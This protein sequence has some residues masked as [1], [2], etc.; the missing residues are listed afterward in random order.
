MKIYYNENY[1]DHFMLLIDEL[2]D[3]LKIDFNQSDLIFKCYSTYFFQVRSNVNNYELLEENQTEEIVHKMFNGKDID[4]D[5]RN[6]KIGSSLIPKTSILY[7]YSL[8]YHERITKRIEKPCIIKYKFPLFKHPNINLNKY[9][10]VP[11]TNVLF[12]TEVIGSPKVIEHNKVEYYLMNGSYISL[13]G[14][15]LTF[16]EIDINKVQYEDFSPDH[17]IDKLYV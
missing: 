8:A 9:T 4:Y 6:L 16:T 5:G 13:K 3:Q 7:S 1:N 2:P 12:N 11:S 10:V 17:V 15:T 14:H